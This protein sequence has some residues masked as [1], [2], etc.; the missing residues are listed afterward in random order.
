MIKN[1]N[2]NFEIDETI[3]LDRDS[4]DWAD[5]ENKLDQVWRKKIKNE[6]LNLKLNGKSSDSYKKT[7]IQRYEG[8][9]RRT[10]Q[11]KSR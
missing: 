7:L 9:A 6:T 1:S 3:A 5:S 10:Q 8:I 4:V 11:I 2:F